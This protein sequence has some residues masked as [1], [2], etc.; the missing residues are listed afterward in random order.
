MRW[1][2][3]AIIPAVLI[4]GPGVGEPAPD[5]TEPDTAGQLHSL[6]DFKYNTIMLHFWH[7]G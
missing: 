3:L 4:G 6:S 5:F 2:M 1:L 7:S